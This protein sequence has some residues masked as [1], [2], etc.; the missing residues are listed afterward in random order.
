MAN[1]LSNSLSA[2]KDHRQRLP[3]PIL[4]LAGAAAICAIAVIIMGSDF[5]MAWAGD[6]VIHL[7][8][9]ELLASGHGFQFNL[10]EPVVA[11]TSLLWT[12]ILA[13]FFS[14]LSPAGVAHAVK[15][16]NVVLWVSTVCVTAI[17]WAQ[18]SKSRWVGWASAAVLALNPG[19]FQNSL[20]GMEAI[21]L[22]LLQITL[23]FLVFG[24]AQP[25]RNKRLPTMAIL[26]TLAALTRPEGILFC[27][28]LAGF[29]AWQKRS[30][31]A[32]S[33]AILAGAALGTAVMAGINLQVSGQPDSRLRC[34]QDG[35]RPARV[36]P[37]WPG[38]HPS[39]IRR[40][41]GRLL[42]ADDRS[43]VCRICGHRPGA[44]AGRRTGSERRAELLSAARGRDAFLLYFHLWRHTHD[45]LLDSVFSVRG[46]RFL[47][48][49]RLTVPTMPAMAARD[50][51][52]LQTGSVC[53]NGLLR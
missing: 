29:L 10:G 23:F 45:S 44:F 11:T 49:A 2:T 17:A 50:A 52:P 7:R 8:V 38:P 53:Q 24:Q 13:G 42:A 18:L 43:A 9:A 20:N 47:H 19:V 35:G 5:L 26:A 30:L 15:I 31:P 14:L 12:F 32:E 3:E 4:Q 27:L 41:P 22:A 16:L 34:G 37:A 28:L 21:L 25:T 6:A 36:H 51:R 48:W 1:H 33:I 46:R 39:Q 40:A